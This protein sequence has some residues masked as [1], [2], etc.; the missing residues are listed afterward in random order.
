MEKELEEWIEKYDEKLNSMGFHFDGI[1]TNIRNPKTSIFYEKYIGR[2]HYSDYTLTLVVNYL[3][4]KNRI[5]VNLEFYPEDKRKK[6]TF[7]NYF[8]T[9]R[10]FELLDDISKDWVIE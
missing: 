3:K 10:A 9:E 1:A 7:F 4:D 5:E 6:P 8:T 2:G